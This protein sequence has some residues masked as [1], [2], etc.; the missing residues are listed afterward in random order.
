MHPSTFNDNQCE[1]R[2]QNF[3]LKLGYSPTQCSELY[4]TIAF[5]DSLR[6]ILQ[7]GTDPSSK[8]HQY[9]LPD[10]HPSSKWQQ[11]NLSDLDEKF[12]DWKPIETSIKK[13]A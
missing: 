12:G 9:N 1:S 10:L 7:I 11:Y 5:S 6:S 3:N 8:Y 4:P 13:I 2:Y